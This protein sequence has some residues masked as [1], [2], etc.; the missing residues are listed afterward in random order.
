MPSWA[1]PTAEEI[2]QVALL[3]ARPEARA[4]FFDRLENPN[5]VDALHEAGFFTPPDPVP[6]GDG[7]VQFPPWPEGRYLAR[8]AVLAPAAVSAVL[9]ALGLQANPAATRA[10]LEAATAL[11]DEHLTDLAERVVEWVSGPHP[12]YFSEQA[13]VIIRRLLAI[14]PHGL[15]VMR[16]LLEIRPDPRRAE[17]AASTDGIIRAS[18]DASSRLSDW[19]YEHAIQSLVPDLVEKLGLDGVRALSDL[20]NDALL[21]SAWDD[22]VDG[23]A[24]SYIWRPAIEDHPQNEDSA[25][26]NTLTSA[27]RDAA[28]KYASRGRAELG[29]VVAEVES[30]SVLHRRI[31]LHVL[32]LG[33]ADTALVSARVGDRQLFNDHRLR[34]EYSTLL[35]R[36]FGNADSEAQQSV[37]HWIAD[38]PDVEDYRQRHLR[39]D[40]ELPTV[41]AVER[42]QQ[43]WQRDWYSFIEQYLDEA[44]AAV[45][46]DLVK[47]L[48]PAEHP[49]FL[50]WSSSWVGPESPHSRDDLHRLEVAEVTNLLRSWRPEDASSWHFG[51]SIEGLGR[52]LGED[53]KERASAY[54]A[55]A[56]TFINL[57]P[58]YVRSIFSGLESALRDGGSIDWDQSL[59]LAEY[60]VSQPFEPDEEVPDLDRD[61][62]W[63]WCRRE[64]ASF[65]RAGFSDRPNRIP[66][67]QRQRAWSV[68]ERLL[69]DPNP[70]PEHEQRYGGDNMDP[71]TLSINTNRGTAMHAVIEYALWVRR[72]LEASGDDVSVGFTAM[73]EVRHALDAHLDPHM[74]P[75]V[76]VHA[77]Y[78]RWL[79]WLLLLDEAWVQDRHQA[80]FP[81]EPLETYRDVVWATYISW[82]PPYDSAFRTLR[83]DYEAFVQAVPSG[84]AAGTLHKE[85]VDAKLGQHLVTFF[86][87]GL[88]DISLLD[89]FFDRADDELAS[90]VMEFVGRVLH[91][92]TGDLSDGIRVRIQEL[93]ERRL[94]AGAE[95]PKAHQAELRA[96]GMTFASAKLD[97]EW[98]LGN[99]ERAVA[100]A[101]APKLGQWVVERLVDLVLSRPAVATRILAGMLE[102]PENEWDHIGWRDEARAIVER[103][104]RRG[105]SAAVDSCR[106]IVDNYVRHGELDFRGLLDSSRDLPSDQ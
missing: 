57:D 36:Q 59:T 25:V 77:V 6:A 43:T 101:G 71:L 40:G 33:D 27:V 50:S 12:D 1:P 79:P 104:I 52:V 100:L 98:T 85:S 46:S 48:G 17:K 67:I 68:I 93:W 5:W 3:A 102:H 72:E 60:V 64:V 9:T 22:E 66:F 19:E 70:S 47:S 74:D 4:Y 34:H 89:E 10:L 2:H 76:A 82:C 28:L 24:H 103:A 38:G 31:G 61:P 88:A 53:V 30:R 39:F 91:N 23:A 45:Y 69:H 105:D 7:Y 83:S 95:D 14:E 44:T 87:R 78:G 11:P 65:M 8:A 92:T 97:P 94:A 29:E 58:T 56:S 84:V 54:S 86:W 35:R 90:D 42:Y 32:A 21:H 41:E 62:G 16:A 80:L 51:P 81:S 20:L 26:K 75:S 63:R 37:L 96:F 55:S 18:L 49:D 13:V 99:L 106:S 15:E 73:P